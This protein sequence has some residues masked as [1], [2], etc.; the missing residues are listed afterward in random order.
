[1]PAMKAIFSRMRAPPKTSVTR[2]LQSPLVAPVPNARLSAGIAQ[3]GARMKAPSPWSYHQKQNAV[4][5]AMN[6]S[7]SARAAP[8]AHWG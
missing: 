3:Y 6:S 8:R 5:T 2:S 1:M 4:A 7:A